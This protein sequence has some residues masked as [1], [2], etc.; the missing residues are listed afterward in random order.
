MDIPRRLKKI[1]EYSKAGS[2]MGSELQDPELKS[3][4]GEEMWKHFFRAKPSCNS[5]LAKT[6]SSVED[7]TLKNAKPELPPEEPTESENEPDQPET[8]PADA[9]KTETETETPDS[10]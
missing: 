7:T 6:P 9:A 2:Y 1:K 8:G 3:K 4:A 10:E 5:V